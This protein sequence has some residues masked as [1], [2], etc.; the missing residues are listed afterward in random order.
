MTKKERKDKEYKEYVV[1][2]ECS[3]FYDGN[4][5]HVIIDLVCRS[6]QEAEEVLKS[7]ADAYKN[8]RILEE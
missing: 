1:R 5:S 2:G 6:K 8:L 7:R 4:K 3:T